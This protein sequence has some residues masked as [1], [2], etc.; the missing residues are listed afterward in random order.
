MQSRNDGIDM[1]GVGAVVS[2]VL[3]VIKVKLIT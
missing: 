3:E 2:R 1:E